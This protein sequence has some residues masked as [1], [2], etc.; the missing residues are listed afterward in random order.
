MTLLV[1]L[2]GFS[3]LFELSARTRRPIDLVIFEGICFTP[4]PLMLAI[5][6]PLRIAGT[7]TIEGWL[8]ASMQLDSTLCVS[9]QLDTPM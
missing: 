9:L 5:D 7:F 2:L 4:L 1:R 3:D 6:G 8:L